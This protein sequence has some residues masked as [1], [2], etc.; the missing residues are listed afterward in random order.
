M[1]G[2]AGAAN[3]KVWGIS[4]TIIFAATA[5]C[6]ATGV[7]DGLD[8]ASMLALRGGE[9]AATTVSAIT[10]IT[11]I[12]ASIVRLPVALVAVALLCAVRRFPAAW[13]IAVAVT[14]GLILT[15]LL[16]LIFARPRPDLM[17]HLQQVTSTGFPSGHALGATVTYGAL[18]I[19]IG[20]MDDRYRRSAMAFVILLVGI[21][22]LT[23]IYLG[24][25]MLT[26]VVAGWSVGVAW[27][28]LCLAFARQRRA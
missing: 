10:A 9:P 18:A 22:G 2:K 8:R 26:D 24:V 27:L 13:F 11:D 5:V 20:C 6:V 19:V 28:A 17:P 23:R 1:A 3:L 21:I 16:K 14:G 25:H 4:A 15:G 12:G 7:T